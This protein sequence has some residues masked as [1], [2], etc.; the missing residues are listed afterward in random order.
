ME[1]GSHQYCP[2]GGWQL[3][4]MDLPRFRAELL[5]KRRQHA[6]Y[7]GLVEAWNGRVISTR[8]DL[9]VRDFFAFLE[10]AYGELAQRDPA[11]LSPRDDPPQSA[12]IGQR[13]ELEAALGAA[14]PMTAI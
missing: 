14:L 8:A 7:D 10:A 12:D 13:A 1:L 9:R 6:L 2:P 11:P 3:N 5:E 4:G